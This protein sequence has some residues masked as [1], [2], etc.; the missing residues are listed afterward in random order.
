MFSY[1]RNK[2]NIGIFYTLTVVSARNRKS[3]GLIRRLREEQSDVSENFLG[4]NENRTIQ[5]LT[6]SMSTSI[7]SQ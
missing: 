5:V 7:T 1:L 4:N 6:R 3:E 2:D